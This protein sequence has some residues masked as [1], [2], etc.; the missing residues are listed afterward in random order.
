MMNEL[1]SQN[2]RDSDR[3]G[4]GEACKRSPF[5]ARLAFTG[6]FV[7]FGPFQPPPEAARGL[8]SPKLMKPT[9]DFNL[10]TQME[11]LLMR[12]RESQGAKH[13]QEREPEPGA[14]ATS[15]ISRGAASL[16]LAAR[17]SRA[18]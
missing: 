12:S 8:R 15:Q 17:G 13:P 9:P 4:D 7:S 11:A 18:E 14:A 2:C 10:H 16:F 5:V 6:I 3:V 1:E